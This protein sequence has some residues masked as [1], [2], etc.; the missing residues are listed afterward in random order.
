MVGHVG[1]AERRRGGRSSTSNAEPF[2]LCICM[3]HAEAGPVHSQ[4]LWVLFLHWR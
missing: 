4:W 2:D 1:E 3:L